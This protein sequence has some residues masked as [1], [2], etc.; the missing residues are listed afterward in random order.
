MQITQLSV[1]RFRVFDKEC[2]VPLAPFTV[3]TGPNNLGKSTVLRVLNVFFDFLQRPTLSGSFRNRVWTTTRYHPEDDY[4]Q[5]RLNKRGRRYSTRLS[6]EFEFSES[7][8]ADAARDAALFLPE[9]LRIVADYEN[10]TPTRPRPEF[11]CADL[12]DDQ[13]QS[14]LQWLSLNFRYIYI[15]AT[16]NVDDFRRFLFSEL[17]NASFQR[18]RQ[19]KRR[20]ELIERF[21]EDVRREMG[22][23][24]QRLADE[25]RPYLPNIQS[26]EIVSRDIDV[27]DLIG[28]NE[29]LIDDGAKTSLSQKGDGVKSLFVMAVLQFLAKQRF[30]RNLVFGIEEP[31]SHLHSSAIYELK[32]S[33]RELS[34]SFQILITTHSPILIER[35]N[36]SHNVIIDQ[37]EQEKFA[38]TAHAARNLSEIR[39]SLGIKPQDNM[40]TAEVVVVVEGATEERCLTTLFRA[41][42]ADLATAITEGRIRIIGAGGATKIS[43]VVRAL[44]RDATSCVVLTDA[45]AEGKAANQQLRRSGLISAIDVFQ[46]RE[47]NGCAETEFEDAFEPEVWVERVAGACGVAIDV[48]TFRAEQMRTGGRG[49]RMK[50]WSDVWGEIVARRG[51]NW[52]DLQETA[53]SSF[54][55]AV[56]EHV[57]RITIGD[58]PWCE[59]IEERVSRLLAER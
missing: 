51:K 18:V 22:S 35:D 37:I 10:C 43:S 2:S 56:E 7:D 14:F 1:R 8:Q 45:D 54:A 24:E 16:R 36:L 47:R 6:V 20:L 26:L 42:S 11:T 59:S 32:S 15:P 53:K 25:L 28:I 55:D 48:P 33:L 44:A 12:S 39:Q 9:R 57:D 41:H 52:E 30:G 17:V 13:L 23:V 3:L 21:Y 27:A 29:I 40:V 58:V 19:S 5:H 34:S 38:C 49:N 4:P 46:V 50:K 31:E